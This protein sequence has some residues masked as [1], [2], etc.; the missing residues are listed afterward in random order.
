LPSSFDQRAALV[1]SSGQVTLTVAAQDTAIAAGSG[2]IPVL[3][4]PRLVALMEAAACEALRGHLAP[5]QTSVGANITLDHLR[6]SLVGAVVTARA[7]IVEIDG[8]RV[9]F[10]VVADQPGPNGVVTIGTG[11][12]LRVVVSR[13]KFLQRAR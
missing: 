10:A 12:H 5:E 7:E 3:A 8:D 4:T 2:D 1:G 9:H 11:T 6:P 13:E